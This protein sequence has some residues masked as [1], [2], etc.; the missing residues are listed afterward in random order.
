PCVYDVPNM[1]VLRAVVRETSRWRP[2]IAFGVPH[3]TNQD[4]VYNGYH[5]AK[6]KWRANA[7]M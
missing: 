7:S 5:I 1:P 6:G 2:P 3:I 4:N